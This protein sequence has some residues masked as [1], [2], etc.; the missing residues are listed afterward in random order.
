MKLSN[1]P[2]ENQSVKSAEVSIKV[3]VKLPTESSEKDL[4]NQKNQNT[5]KVSEKVDNFKLSDHPKT[6]AKTDINDLETILEKSKRPIII[7]EKPWHDIEHVRDTYRFKTVI[8]DFDQGFLKSLGYEVK[9]T[10]DNN[11]DD[12]RD[13]PALDE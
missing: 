12:I 2:I 8:D 13:E 4:P 10:R 11:V 6:I 3:E 1:Q 5:I 9:D 7:K